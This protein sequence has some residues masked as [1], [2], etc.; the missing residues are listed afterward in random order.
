V[1]LAGTVTH[2]RDWD[3]LTDVASAFRVKGSY[4]ETFAETWAKVFQE[5]VVAYK[6]SNPNFFGDLNLSPGN[7]VCGAI[8]FGW[9]FGT[10]QI[11]NENIS[12][13]QGGV[14]RESTTQLPP[15]GKE[16]SLNP[17]T[18]E[19]IKSSSDRAKATA[20]RWRTESRHYP[21][22]EL[23]WRHMEFLIRETSKLDPTVSPTSDVLEITASNHLI[24]HR[25]VACTEAASLHH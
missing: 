14:K 7:G 16:E 12:A 23:D 17:I 21:K 9:V 8:F 20:Q 11:V 4:P 18:Q 15:I 19:L 1:T 3:A 25:R 24:W 5:H 13:D 2:A 6:K 22:G 10:P